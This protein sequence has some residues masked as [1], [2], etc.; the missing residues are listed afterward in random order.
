VMVTDAAIGQG[1]FGK[2]SAVTLKAKVSGGDLGDRT[3][4][5]M[6]IKT[7][8]IRREKD[9]APSG[10]DIA[11]LE[12]YLAQ[13]NAAD[14]LPC[15]RVIGAHK[16]QVEEEHVTPAKGKAPAKTKKVKKTVSVT[17]E[18]DGHDPAKK[19]APAQVVQIDGSYGGELARALFRFAYSFAGDKEWELGAL[20]CTDA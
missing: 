10:E 19:G 5:D 6:P 18:Y 8:E 17:D 4:T 12:L 7:R 15:Y 2:A 16:V 20:K 9:G 3:D 11:K 1:S 13:I 14:H